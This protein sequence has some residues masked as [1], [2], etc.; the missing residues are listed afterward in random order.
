[1]KDFSLAWVDML[2]ETQW[3]LLYNIHFF[4]GDYE[5]NS[6]CNRSTTE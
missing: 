6:N 3:T 2:N 5:Y 1:M 4:L